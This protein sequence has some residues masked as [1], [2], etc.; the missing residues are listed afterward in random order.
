[1]LL[2]LVLLS[3]LSIAYVIGKEQGKNDILQLSL[4]RPSSPS[5]TTGLEHALRECGLDREAL[6]RTYREEL[7]RV[8]TCRL[9]L[10]VC[11]LSLR[12]R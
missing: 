6:R 4:P 1:M 2:S 11:L 7:S 8:N 10:R 9:E 12:D 5:P 3:L